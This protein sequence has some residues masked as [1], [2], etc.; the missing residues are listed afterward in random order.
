MGKSGVAGLGVLEDKINKAADLIARL[1]QE[2]IE[3]EKVNK[4]LEEKIEI[5]YIRNKELTKEIEIL[6]KDIRK[7][8][9][10]KTREEITQ[11]IEEMLAKL[12]ELGV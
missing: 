3:V 8:F 12:E 4:E 6:K 5:L 1:K 9:D 11:K 2:K 10:S 7:D